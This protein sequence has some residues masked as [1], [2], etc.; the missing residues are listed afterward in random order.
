M[1]NIKDVAKLAG[2]SI[3][4]VSRVVN[5]SAGVAKGKS[6]AVL[7]AMKELNYQPNTFAKALVS[8]K[9]DTIGVLVG[10]LSEPFFGQMMQGIENVAHQ[11][12]KQLIMCAGHQN[13]ELERA[14][15]QSL[16]N[17]RCDALIIHSKVLTDYQL[18]ELLEQHPAT[19]LINR[20]IPDIK[21]RC[22]DIDNRMIGKM[23]CQ[24]LLDNGHRQIATIMAS[25]SEVDSAER[26]QGY[27]DALASSGII[28]D[29][30]LMISAPSTLEDA[31]KA[32]I[33]LLD[34]NKHFSAIFAYNCIMSAGVIKALK[35]RKINI[36]SDM[37]VIGIG[38]GT[39]AQ[40]LCPVLSVGHYPILD[41]GVA[42]AELA[43]SLFDDKLPKPE[44]LHFEP[45]LMPGD[46]VSKR[47]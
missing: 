31:Y 47:H 20:Q 41:M 6:E 37:S 27:Q 24:H 11:Y 14:A 7:K 34:K 16:I 4:T 39:L 3:S 13:A 30:D 9:S 15:I 32:T 17:R 10:N 5:N 43:M 40:Y 18:M 1:A 36:P 12:N 2:V 45:R 26:Q 21:D 29:P 44:H 23:V 42:A 8:N 22:I 19:V 28:P 46:T 35:D 38:D 33:E 25:N